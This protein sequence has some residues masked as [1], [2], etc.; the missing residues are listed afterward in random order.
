MALPDQFGQVPQQHEAS[1]VPVTDTSPGFGARRSS[2]ALGCPSIGEAVSTGSGIVAL[3]PILIP[4]PIAAVVARFRFPCLGR[5]T[6]ETD[7]WTW[8]GAAEHHEIRGYAGPGCEHAVRQGDHGIHA[9]LRQQRLP[10]P[11]VAGAI[12]RVLRQHDDRP[13]SGTQVRHDVLQEQALRVATREREPVRGRV[14]ASSSPWRSGKD[15]V[16]A[17]RRAAARQRPFECVSQREAGSLDTGQQRSAQPDR[18][19]DPVDFD[20]KDLGNLD[21]GPVMR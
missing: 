5:D 13:S 10:Q 3:T 21:V 1:Y 17:V 4:H 16:E 20:S 18:V 9:V 12:E 8:V 19:G 6:D 11:P 7:G 2:P 14:L 15:A